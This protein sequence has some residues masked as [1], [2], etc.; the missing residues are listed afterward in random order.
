MEVVRNEKIS[1]DEKNIILLTLLEIA[2]EEVL[3]N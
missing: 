2:K 1:E 3:A